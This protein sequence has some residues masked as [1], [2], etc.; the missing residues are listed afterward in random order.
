[1]IIYKYLLG[2][3]LTQT[4]HMP[5][6]AKILKADF[7]GHALFLWALVDSSN[8]PEPRQIVVLTTG[9]RFDLN[10]TYISTAFLDGTVWHVFE[11]I[12]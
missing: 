10:V 9:R 8:P 1:M 4:I 3:E 6:G 2:C 5:K 11:E 7:Q 12:S